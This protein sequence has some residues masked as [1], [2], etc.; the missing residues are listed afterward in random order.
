M[1]V[2]QACFLFALKECVVSISPVLASSPEVS[3]IIPVRN[4]A[5]NIAPLAAEIIAA[6]EGVCTFEMIYVNDGSTDGTADALAALMARAPRVRVLAHAESCGQSCAVRSG[7][8]AARGGIIMTLDGDGQNN[9]AFLP[10][11]LAKLKEGGATCGLVQGQRI[12][13]KSGAFKKLQSAIANGVRRFL[14]KDGTR[15]TGCGLKCFYRTVYLALPY[16]DAL[17]RFMPALVRREGF[18]VAYVVVEDRLRL[19]G[20]SNYGFFDRL[21][22]GIVDLLGVRW[23]IARRA[24]LPRAEEVEAGARLP[25][26][27]EVEAGARFADAGK[28]L[29]GAQTE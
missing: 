12:K 6:L 9:P 23:L 24:R 20:T 8:Y 25:R 3:V 4:E 22:V 29:R 16:F 17:H 11:L 7:V 26:A 21:F 1:G 2:F 28:G 5:G 15:D 13:R 14:L 10:A 27:E 18:D 19:T